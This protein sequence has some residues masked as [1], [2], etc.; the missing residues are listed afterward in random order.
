VLSRVQRGLE[1]LYRVETELAVDDYV[2]GAAQREKLGL[3][4][5]PREQLLFTQDE[6][7][8]SLGLF[9]D[10]EV[11]S[12]LERDDPSERLHDGNLQD[13][14]FVVEGVSHFVLLAWRARHDRQV[15]GLELEL[16][17][18]V[19]KY[20]TC[21]LTWEEAPSRSRRL[22]QRLFVDMELDDD[23]DDEERDRY[24]Q[25]NDNAY[26]YSRSLEERYV[27]PRRIGEMLAEL[28]RFYR[29]PLRA[30]LEHIQ[31]AA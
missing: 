9:V 17:A 22:R 10:E 21:L 13:F 20:V 29:M 4:R 12:N 5:M 3:S 6:E 23:L 2:I 7:G 1:R 19:D 27:R 8:L 30:K 18:E 16:Q 28:R 11:L 31:L 25:A 14:L 26:R 15:S 24:L